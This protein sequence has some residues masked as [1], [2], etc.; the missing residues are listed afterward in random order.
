LNLAEIANA[1]RCPFCLWQ[2][3]HFTPTAAKRFALSRSDV[4]QGDKSHVEK[5]NTENDFRSDF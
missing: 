5:K 3:A 1:L 2:P 4:D